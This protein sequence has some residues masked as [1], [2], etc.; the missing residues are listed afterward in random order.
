M[1]K[2]LVSLPDELH[3]ALRAIAFRHRTSM[4]ELVRSATETVYE[5]EMDAIEAE[6]GL[7]EYLADPS[8]S[9]SLDEYVEKRRGAVR[10]SA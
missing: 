8:S 5:D 10:R 1:K 7:E 9:I 6:K 4:A 2:L 3:E